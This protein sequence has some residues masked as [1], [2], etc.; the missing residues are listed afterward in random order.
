MAL[1]AL[2]AA[3]TT[4]TSAL[5]AMATLLTSAALQAQPTSRLPA[6]LQPLV[7]ALKAKGFTVRIALPPAQR[8]YGLFQSQTRTLWISPL[9]FPLGIARQTFLHEAVHAVQSCPTGRLTPIGWRI[10]VSP[11]VERE[12]SGILL[13]SYH[14]GSRALEREAFGMQGQR[15]AVRQVIA[16]LNERCS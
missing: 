6:D 2:A 13:Q 1:L 9:T 8:S 15:D 5:L 14:H 11:V 7:Q 16:A 4:M 10:Q 3:R 12:I